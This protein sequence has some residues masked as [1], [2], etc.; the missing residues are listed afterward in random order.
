M[1]TEIEQYLRM[2][3]RAAQ[4]ARDPVMA[5]AALRIADD[6]LRAL[7]DPAYTPV[8][9]QVG[10]EIDALE[11]LPQIDVEGIALRLGRLASR[12]D[13]LPLAVR[14]ED[15]VMAAGDE[16]V[17]EPG[18]WSRTWAAVRGAL[19]SLVSV[20]RTDEDAAPMLAPE[21]EYFLREN[22]RLQLET[23][24]LALLRGDEANFTASLRQAREW[25]E[26][27]FETDRTRIVR[28]TE[29]LEKLAELK[30]QPELP[31]LSGS[32]AALRDVGG[33]SAVDDADDQDPI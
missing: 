26:S 32:L 33:D 14:D 3:N 18:F 8:R 12:V 4:L 13:E 17:E 2:A 30:L 16:P 20:R 22:L 9:E 10:T 15:T 1:R 27:Y 11:A 7:D 25:L 28:V 23:A 24:R 31:D 5:L 6:R 21:Q 29:R 19:K